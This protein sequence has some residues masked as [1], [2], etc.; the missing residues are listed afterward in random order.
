MMMS[1]FKAGRTEH[2][3]KIGYIQKPAYLRAVKPEPKPNIFK[4]ITCKIIRDY[5]NIKMV[6]YGT[7]RDM[8]IN[9]KSQ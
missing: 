6:L 2:P 9:E 7:S 8:K 4:T 5:H 1:Y 3:S